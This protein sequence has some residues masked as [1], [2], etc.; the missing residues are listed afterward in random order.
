[1][2]DSDRFRKGVIPGD[3]KDNNGKTQGSVDGIT[4]LI[5]K[6]KD[7]GGGSGGGDKSGG[8]GGGSESGSEK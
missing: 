6:K 4:N 3:K 8:S 1:M 5:R 2:T 7:S